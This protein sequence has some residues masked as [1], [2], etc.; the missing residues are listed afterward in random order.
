MTHDKYDEIAF[1]F[2]WSLAKR[3]RRCPPDSV[4]FDKNP[5]LELNE[6]L[7]F[8]PACRRRL[9]EN[10]DDSV[11][12]MLAELVS[13]EDLPRHPALELGQLWQVATEKGGWAT[14]GYHYNPPRVMVIEI[15]PYQVVRVAQVSHYAVFAGEDDVLAGQPYDGFAEPWN[16][17]SL[18]I[19]W[20]EKYVG[21]ADEEVARRTRQTYEERMRLPGLSSPMNAAAATGISGL[22]DMTAYGTPRDLFRQ[23]EL[24][25]SVYFS[26]AAMEEVMR[27]A[28]AHVSPSLMQNTHTGIPKRLHGITLPPRVDYGGGR[29]SE[30]RLYPLAAAA[31]DKTE[32]LEVRTTR[33]DMITADIDYGTGMV[34]VVAEELN[35]HVLVLFSNAEKGAPLPVRS[36]GDSLGMCRLAVDKPQ[37]VICVDMTGC[38]AIT[39]DV[40]FE[41][42][43]E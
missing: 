10:E 1:A 3:E 25:H 19:A 40:F 12:E 21:M 7:S 18:P 14:D 23:L 20:L 32:I 35:G 8:C 11:F 41:N 37:A 26:M 38:T 28:E 34:H 2:G 6:H 33:G 17:Y 13:A 4:L 15:F 29:K 9:R 5:A 36:G 16:V 43:E 27:L 22:R 31:S 42:T 39:V 30:A 24:T